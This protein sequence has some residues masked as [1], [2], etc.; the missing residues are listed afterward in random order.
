MSSE[1]VQKILAVAPKFTA[2]MSVIGSSMIISCVL[3]SKK[4]RHMVQQR[5]VLS[6]SIIDV[7]VSTSWLFSNLF[8]PDWNKDM[9]WAQGNQSS[10]STQGFIVQ[11][12]ISSVF[13]NSALSLYYL[14]VIQCGWSEER[15]RFLERWIHF[16]SISWG[17]I[18]AIISLSLKLYNPANWDCWIAPLPG[19]CTQSFRMGKDDEQSVPCVR[20]DNATIFQWAFFFAPLWVA[21]LF[22]TVAMISVYYNV[23]FKEMN[24]LRPRP[25]SMHTKSRSENESVD[26]SLKTVEREQCLTYTRQVFEQSVMYVGAFYCTWFFPTLTRIIQLVQTSSQNAGESI[27]DVIILL[28]GICIPI[29]G[30]L[31]ATVYFRPRIKK[32]RLDDPGISMWSLYLKIMRSTLFCCFQTNENV[33]DQDKSDAFQQP[34]S[35]SYFISSSVYD[36]DCNG[37]SSNPRTQ[38]DAKGSMVSIVEEVEDNTDDNI[39][40]KI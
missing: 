22:V 29:Q 1:T 16:I 38:G 25:L 30:A 26:S 3:R 20:G 6:M 2:L 13:Y 4:N 19:N 40:E 12:S 34:K 11:F 32:Y 15:F 8:V 39:S 14:L 36:V 5:I 17:L 27:P 10:C 24:M 18:T 37:G 33:F 7:I 28:S 31:N 21:I 35:Y 9:Y 23:R